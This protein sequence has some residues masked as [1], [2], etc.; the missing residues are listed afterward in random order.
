MSFRCHLVALMLAGSVGGV[1]AGSAA[2]APAQS[3]SA[4]AG[5][6][7]MLPYGTPAPS[8]SSLLPTY[9]ATSTPLSGSPALS[10]YS[11]AGPQLMAAAPS[12]PGGIS[13]PSTPGDLAAPGTPLG[14]ANAELSTRPLN[15]NAYGEPSLLSEEPWSWQVVPPGLMYKSYLAGNREPRLGSQLV[16]ERN[17][18]WTWDA[19]VG[20]R[21]GILRYG[22]DN[23]FWPQ[24][25]QLDVE[26]AAFPRL[27]LEHNE[28]LTSVDFRGG[29]L[30][31]TRQGPW[32]TK[33]GF[34]HISSHIGD[35][36]L[37]R[38]PDFPRLNYVR[39]SL[40]AG[41]AAYLNPSLR[42][43]SEA[44]WAFQEDGGAK[45]WEFQFGADFSPPSRPA[46]RGAPFFAINGHLRQ[47]NDF[48]GNVTVQTG[49]Q[50]RGRSGHLFRV[51]MQYF[52]G[53][54]DQ[55]QFYNTFEEQIGLGLWY[56]YSGDS[57][58]AMAGR[59]R[60]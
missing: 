4:T 18:G 30:S 23:D 12:G 44:G 5:P 13:S 59:D 57:G 20:G 29:L 27:D 11:D 60:N 21:A 6:Q 37:L 39:E 43:Y 53:M 45:P 47:E 36:Y 16:H 55:G 25:W 26:G 35:E 33:F 15:L 54:S 24:G 52:N 38:N 49:W 3:M 50:W 28:D 34:Y 46:P 10:P 8:A 58:S 56:D 9:P 14:G 1:F 40:V 2:P 22:T 19:T 31:T 51:G 32:E 41:I 42:V 7:R 17:L 48:G